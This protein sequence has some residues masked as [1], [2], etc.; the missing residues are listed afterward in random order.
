VYTVTYGGVVSCLDAASGKVIFRGR[1]GALGAYFSSPVAA[2]GRIYFA[3]EEGVVSVIGT[4]DKLDVLARNNLE[5][6]IFAT[7]A[8]VESVIYIRTPAH[9]YAFGK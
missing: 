4:G 9:V 7:P 3:S 2:A 1:L 5:E 6:P 8:I